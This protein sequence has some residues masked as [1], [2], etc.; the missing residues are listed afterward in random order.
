MGLNCTKPRY[1]FTAQADFRVSTSVCCHFASAAH[2]LPSSLPFACDPNA[3]TNY[4]QDPIAEDGGGAAPVAAPG[5]DQADGGPPGPTP[6]VHGS[7]EPTE[8]VRS[9]ALTSERGVWKSLR[10]GFR[11]GVSH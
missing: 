11:A 6:V 5:G 1:R 4:V 9:L 8:D 7:Y 10:T 3:M 2:F